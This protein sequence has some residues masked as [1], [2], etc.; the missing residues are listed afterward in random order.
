M[1]TVEA[2]I[3][4]PAILVGGLLSASV[5]AVVAGQVACADAAREAALLIARGAN[6]AEVD[7]AVDA[8]A[9][10]GAVVRVGRAGHT[11]WVEVTAS[12]S[13]GAGPLA[14]RAWVPL[15]GHAVAAREPGV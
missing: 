6:A 1:V 11:V 15:S 5:P 12:V 4:I 3:A 13:M 7:A 9:P 8:L 10:D 2:A 14:G